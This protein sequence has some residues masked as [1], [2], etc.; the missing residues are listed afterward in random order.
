M[1]E[2]SSYSK[3]IHVVSDNREDLSHHNCHNRHLPK[4]AIASRHEESLEVFTQHRVG[5]RCDLTS[6]T[7]LFLFEKF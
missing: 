3:F 4:S 2:A 6:L 5:L 1:A 7:N